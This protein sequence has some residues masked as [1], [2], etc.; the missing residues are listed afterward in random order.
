MPTCDN[1]HEPIAFDSPF[2]ALCPLCALR[3]EMIQ[4][5][6]AK[7]EEIKAADEY[8]E[9]AVE[10]QISR[11]LKAEEKLDKMEEDRDAWKAK[12]KELQKELDK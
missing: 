12:A 11:A 10:A 3:R 2:A 4:A 6:N 1:D 5:L 7:D 9:E 8:G